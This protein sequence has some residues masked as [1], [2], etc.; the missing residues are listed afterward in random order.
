MTNKIRK[1]T[2]AG[3]DLTGSSGAASRTYNLSISSGYDLQSSSIS[4][5]SN[6]TYLHV[7][8]SNDYTVSGTT[9]TFLV[10]IFDNAVIDIEWVENS[11]DAS[12]GTYYT[13]TKGLA[14]EGGIGLDIFKENVGTGNNSLSS[15]TLDNQQVVDG[16]YT[17]YHAASGSNDF[18]SL[19]E[20][21]HYSIDIDRGTILLTSAGVTALGTDIL[22]ADYMYTTQI[23]DSEMALLLPKI[24]EEVDRMT[25]RTWGTP[26]TK[27]AFFDFRRTFTY[28]TTDEPFARDW[29]EPDELQLEGNITEVDYAY[30]LKKNATFTAVYSNDGGSYTDNTKEANS[31]E[32]TAFDIFASTS[33]NND[34][35]YFGLSSRFFGMTL[36]LATL[37]VDGGSTDV[38]WYYYNGTTWA[39]FTPTEQTS[40]AASFTSNGRLTWD[41]LDAWEKTV[42]NSSNS[43]YFI[44][45]VLTTANYTTEPTGRYFALDNNCI[46]D[47]EIPLSSIDWDPTGRISFIDKRIPNGN[48]IVKVVYKAGETTTN[49]LISELSNLI[50]GLMVFTKITGKSIDTPSTYTM[51]EGSVSVGQLYVNVAEVAKQM[52]KRIAEIMAQLGQRV[53]IFAI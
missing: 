12:A 40:G 3:S 35:I 13:D 6:R 49:P 7:G 47:E 48:R 50:G 43:Y 8:A 52:R 34:E 29:D 10:N 33:A 25:G 38:D 44:K 30:F 1:V 23:S 27:T 17:I 41:Y 46:V 21:T 37:G 32:G 20:T 18:T 53:D 51:P 11:T 4:V 42:V 16:T 14:R 31:L 45:A 26:S 15:F 9:I 2:I 36:R 5:H 24:N 19:T 22:Y 39:S 28:P